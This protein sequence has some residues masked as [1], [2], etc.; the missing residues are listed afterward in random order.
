MSRSVEPMKTPF[1]RRTRLAAW[2][3][4]TVVFA[5]AALVSISRVREVRTC[6]DNMRVILGAM[7][8]YFVHDEQP[9]PS[10]EAL[11]PV[12][13]PRIPLCPSG[14]VYAIHHTP[15][16]ALNLPTCSCGNPR[17]KI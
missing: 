13:L 1:R 8:D 11:T 9:A 4:V 14:G 16:G 6:R 10:I 5:V 12:Y 17:H 7:R 3:T 2:V 15:D